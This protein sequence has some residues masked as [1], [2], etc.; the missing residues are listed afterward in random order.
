M[1]ARGAENRQK[2]VAERQHV[3]AQLPPG[4]VNGEMKKRRVIGGCILTETHFLN[5]QRVASHSHETAFFRLIVHGISTDRTARRTWRAG[6]STMVFHPSGEV[7]A[8]HWHRSGRGFMIEVGADCI[9]RLRQHLAVPDSSADF[10]RG[11][12]IL[13]ATRIFAEFRND[14]ILSDL[15][16]EGLLLEL[17]AEAGRGFRE[18]QPRRGPRWLLEVRD[19]LHERFADNVSLAKLAAAVGVHPAHLA[20]AF[21]KQHGCTAGEYLRRLRLDHAC[22]ELATTDAPLLRIALGAGFT[23]QSHFCSCFK[24]HIGMSPGAYRRLFPRR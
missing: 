10:H 16:I 1:M 23:D 5:A 11:P 6:P 14:D 22:H 9:Q 8:N 24:R 21:R 4:T 12:A 3:N 19:L 18:C 13:L 15:S 20:R 7:H 17:L 2:A